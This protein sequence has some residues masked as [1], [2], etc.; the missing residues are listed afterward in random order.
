MK[1]QRT[2]WAALMAGVFLLTLFIAALPDDAEARARRGGRSFSR[3]FSRPAQPR[4]T[5]NQRRTTSSANR[6][7][8]SRFGGSSFM[9]GLGGGLLGGM[10]GGMLFGRPS[11]GGM[12]AGGFGGSGIGLIEILLLAGVGWFLFKRFIRPAQPRG[13]SRFDAP[14]FDRAQ[15]DWRGPVVDIPPAGSGGA[16]TASADTAASG[17]AEIRQSDPRFDPDLFKE[18]AQ[19]IFFKIQAA[20]MRR[21]VDSVQGLLGSQLA[22]EYREQF[23][24]MKARGQVN[25]L[26][27][28]AVRKVDIVDAGIQGDYAFVVVDFTANLLDYTVEETSGRV[29]EGSDTEPV[30]FQERWTF[31]APVNSSDWRLEGIE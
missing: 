4:Q 24:E 3:T 16:G 7:G 22:G 9:R 18:G 1:N 15:S 29:V 20:W 27:N 21:E 19:D 12:G 14:G 8:T 10:I 6:T 23:A 17:I 28:I 25:R 11:Y 30:K 13:P 2:I 26:E 5:L 31:G